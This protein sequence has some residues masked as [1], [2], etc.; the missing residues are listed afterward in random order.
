MRN[1]RLHA[2]AP[3]RGELEARLAALAE[4]DALDVEQK[5]KL[6]S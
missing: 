2:A 3:Q 6:F 1:S 5:L 4:L